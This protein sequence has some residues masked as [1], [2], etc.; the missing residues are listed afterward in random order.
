[1]DLS[2]KRDTV[3]INETV[4]ES[5]AEHPV[6]CDVVL[7]DYCPDIARILKT[8][9]CA[10]VDSKTLET[11]RLTVNGNLCV[12]IIY[13][14]DN[15]SDIRCF[16]YDNDFTHTFDKSG[17]EHDDF[18]KAC[19][20]I[21]Y[22][23][24]RS[25]GP[26]RLQIKAC[27]S[28]TAKV[29]SCRDEEFITGCEDDKIEMLS[30]PMKMSSLVG[31]AEKAFE[32]EEELEVGYGKPA[33]AAI[34]RSDA[35]AIVQDCKTI[36]N[37]IIAKGELQLHTLYTPVDESTKIEVMDNTV[38][39]SQII[40]IEGVDENSV[41]S[42][43]FTVS[44]V[45]VEVTADGDGETRILM[46]T[47]MLNAQASARNTQEITAVT[48]AYSPVFDMDIQVKPVSVERV[49]DVIRSNQSVRLSADVPGEGISSVKD[50][51]VRVDSANAR[52][53]NGR[54]IISGE[55]VVSAIG[56]D[57][58]DGPACIEKS[59]PYEIS[60][61]MSAQCDNIR[62]DPD[63]SIMSVAFSLAAGKI[64]VRAD[65]VINAIVFGLNTESLIS[66]MSLDET[67]PRQCSQKALTLYFA[68]KG[69]SL[70]SIA[71]HFNT[72]M[73]AIKKENN[74]DDDNLQERSMLLIPKKHC[75]K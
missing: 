55:M 72:S 24:C 8:E 34:I 31:T 35:T 41:C 23:N 64:E 42:V 71:K 49:V 47:A 25:I 28:I 63:I 70:W 61:Q 56:T 65:C 54:L 74:I 1:M 3:R 44:T 6:E 29:W 53:E 59:V 73:N 27:I 39:I 66:E 37:K 60:E 9:A 20:K 40:E 16:T 75:R 17:I 46:M 2:V 52:A 57:M 48:D 45:K 4:F 18:A 33:V 5:T 12:K 19:A 11:D 13:V 62:C 50:C 22:V 10:V 43:T 30:R 32:V 26:R 7:P 14:P 68:E 51:T 58:Q 38:P 69:E 21:D 15:S 67:K 36:K